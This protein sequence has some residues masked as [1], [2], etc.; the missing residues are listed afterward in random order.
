VDDDRDLLKALRGRENTGRPLGDGAFFKKIARPL[1]RDLIP[2]KPGCRSGFQPLG[3]LQR[4]DAASTG[5]S[6]TAGGC[7]FY[8]TKK[9]S[10]RR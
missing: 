2:K 8:V 5:V 9:K 10:K 1:G 6:F 3:F 7:R 4:Q